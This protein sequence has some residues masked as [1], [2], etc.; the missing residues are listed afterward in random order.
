MSANIYNKKII[1]LFP[2]SPFGWPNENADD[3]KA[4]FPNSILVI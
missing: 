3:F 1:A 2:F 4:F